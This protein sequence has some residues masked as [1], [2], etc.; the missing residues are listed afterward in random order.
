M[1]GRPSEGGGGAVEL[2]IEL[3]GAYE[4]GKEGRGQGRGNSPGKRAL[5]DVL[6]R[7]RLK[8]ADARAGD[9]VLG[10]RESSGRQPGQGTTW[11]VVE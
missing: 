4:S 8:D 5:G 2:L 7:R 1:G 9:A 6:G 3:M 10:K 11:G